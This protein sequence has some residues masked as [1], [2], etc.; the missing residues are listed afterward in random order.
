[1]PVVVVTGARQAGKT[2]LA[3]R[4]APGPR[5][6]ETLDDLD[7]LDAAKNDP[8]QLLGGHDAITLDEIQRAPSL[9]AAIKRHVDDART[10]GR[11]L[12]AGS[13]NLA[14]MERVSESLAGRASF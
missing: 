1:M 10:A 5:R 11:F 4:L 8:D 7:V 14:L 6:F 2:T 13:V 3:R 12:L 9:L